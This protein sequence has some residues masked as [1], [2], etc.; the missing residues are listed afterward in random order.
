MPTPKSFDRV[1]ETYDATRGGMRRGR[2]LAADL[3][4]YFCSER[5]VFEVGIG[6]GVVAL[7]LQD[8][9]R[10][11]GG[12]D[13]GPEMAMQAQER[14]GSRVAVADA[15]RL[16]IRD[17]SLSNAYAVLL[18]HLV[19]VG[20]V[21]GEIARTLRPGGRFLVSQGQKRDPT[22]VEII[23]SEMNAALRPTGNRPRLSTRITEGAGQVELSLVATVL[24]ESE[25]YGVTPVKE[26]Q[27]IEDRT[28]SV[29][30]DVDDVRWQSIVE[31]AID[32]I[33]ALPEPEVRIKGN[34]QARIWIFEK[35]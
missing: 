14:I 23:V 21:M 26:A 18:M 8:L 32:K 7:G 31:P 1:A 24:G 4:P 9:G 29:L 19:D 3:N 10:W 15:H 30:W 17:A 12:I 20:V 34:T 16:P 33:R 13:V 28:Y 6:T 22:P 35:R 27:R 5:E 2:R 25:P 11:V